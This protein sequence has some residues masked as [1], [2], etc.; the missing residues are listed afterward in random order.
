MAKPQESVSI[1]GAPMHYSVGALI[2]REGK[3]LLIDRTT[4]P[5]G[6]AG[7]AGHVDQDESPTQALPREIQEEVGLT[8]EESKLLF[9]EELDW[10]QCSKGVGVHY[11]YLFSCEVIGEVKRSDTE[12]KSAQWY[13]K[14]EIAALQLEPVWEYWFKKLHII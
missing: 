5:F 13:T 10:N 4:P 3:Y 2:Q 14:E 8:L 9:E 7:V 11:W 1:G 12:T 6:F